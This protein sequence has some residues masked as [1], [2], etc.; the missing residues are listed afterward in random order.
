MAI[1]QV[2]SI[3]LSALVM[4]VLWGP[5]VGLTRSIATFEPE[6]FLAIVKRLSNNL[7]PVMTVLMPAALLSMVPVLIFA[8]NARPVTFYLTLVAFACFIVALVVTVTTEVPIVK[9]IES[10]TIPTI[11][12]NWERLRDK[13]VSF[14][15]LRV[16]SA[17]A[18]LTLLVAGAGSF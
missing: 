5:W 18:G 11:P 1:Y 8:F 10:R 6:A 15:L 13:W 4:G 16:I 14:H 2:I 3:V 12:D 17:I 7:A 9:Q